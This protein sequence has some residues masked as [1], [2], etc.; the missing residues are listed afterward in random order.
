MQKFPVRYRDYVSITILIDGFKKQATSIVT[1][2]HDLVKAFISLLEDGHY[3]ILN[4]IITINNNHSCIKPILEGIAKHIIKHKR[5]SIKTNINIDTKFLILLSQFVDIKYSFIISKSINLQ[6]TISL[7]EHWTFYLISKNDNIDTNAPCID[8]SKFNYLEDQDIMNILIQEHPAMIRC[9]I[10]FLCNY[11]LSL[12]SLKHAIKVL[13]LLYRLFIA[14]NINSMINDITRQIL[15]DHIPSWILSLKYE[16]DNGLY[17]IMRLK[18]AFD[19]IKSP[20]NIN[21]WKSSPLKDNNV[22]TNIDDYSDWDLVTCIDFFHSQW[23]KDQNDPGILES[24]LLIFQNPSQSTNSSYDLHKCHSRYYYYSLDIEPLSISPSPNEIS[25]F[26]WSCHYLSQDGVDHL[27]RLYSH[28]LSKPL[29]NDIFGYMKRILVLLGLYDIIGTSTIGHQEMDKLTESN[30]K[31]LIPLLIWIISRKQNEFKFLD[32]DNHNQT[33]P[34]HSQN[35]YDDKYDDEERSLK[36]SPLLS[37]ISTNQ[38]ISLSPIQNMNVVKYSIELLSKSLNSLDITNDSSDIIN[39]QEGLMELFSMIIHDSSTIIPLVTFDSLYSY[40]IQESNS[41]SEIKHF[42]L[43]LL[44]W[45]INT[46]CRD[47]IDFRQYHA[48]IITGLSIY[49]QREDHLIQVKEKA[50]CIGTKK[51]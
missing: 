28:I 40:W 16:N 6:K 13:N 31:Q 44:E 30:L 29:H 26:I 14:S 45:I 17:N 33:K 5:I 22:Y 23:S 10:S 24:F 39:Y 32:I 37:P 50:L 41:L 8:T 36:P 7:I 15:K 21:P 20:S 1:W 27:K 34:K 25:W 12:V 11:L 46:W 19:D 18:D 35:D 43:N 4:F 42:G 47:G 2:E 51:L 9:F 48:Q 3:D 49:L 38:C